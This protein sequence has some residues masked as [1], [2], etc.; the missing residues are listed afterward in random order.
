MSVEMRVSELVYDPEPASPQAQ[1]VKPSCHTLYNTDIGGLDHDGHAQDWHDSLAWHEQKIHEKC[2][3]GELNVD[4]YYK[5]QFVLKP[6]KL[7]HR[8]A[9]FDI[10]SVAKAV[11]KQ[12]SVKILL[13]YLAITHFLTTFQHV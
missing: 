9:Q 7:F 8:P 1:E 6:E 10:A 12:R 5:N 2:V 13:S 11:K 4:V 3:D